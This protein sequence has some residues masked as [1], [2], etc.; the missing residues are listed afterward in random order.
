MAAAAQYPNVYCKLSGL[1]NEVQTSSVCQCMHLPPG[2]FL[3]S[4]ELPS[5]RGALPGGVRGGEVH[6]RQV[7]LLGAHASTSDWPV[8]KLGQPYAGYG[9]VVA[10]L[11][12]LTSHLPK[13]DRDKIF[14]QN[15]IDFYNLDVI[16]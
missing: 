5:L 14:F 12:D 4:G 7:G 15:V 6:V 1:I 11:Q 16:E 3:D 13:E 10:L 9:Q 8:C 2:A